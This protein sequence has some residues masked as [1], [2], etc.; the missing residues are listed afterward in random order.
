MAGDLHLGPYDALL[1]DMDGTILTSIAATER[2]WSAW[3]RR[4]GAPVE[5]VLAS[6]H[7]RR[8]VDVIGQFLPAGADISAEVA[9]LDAREL[10]DLDGIEEIPGAGEF[11][12]S[13]PRDRWAIVTS[14]NRE[15]AA[16]RIGAA[17]LPLPDLLVSSD[18]VTA[19]KPDP[20]GYLQAAA[21]LGAHPGRCLVFEDAVAGLRAGV[22]AG[23]QVARIG[24]TG[25]ES[26]V[27]VAAALSGF[28]AVSAQIAV[29]G[30]RLRV[31]PG[32]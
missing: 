2:A 32:S 19:G 28:E 24:I 15:L 3:A 7:G 22:S 14:A 11:L 6:M 23:A 5:T 18:D 21:A 17:G 1:F 29:D 31:Q 8:A 26:P 20:Q 12:S 25:G 4:V 10:E 16:A 13:L 30:V 9:W 27:P